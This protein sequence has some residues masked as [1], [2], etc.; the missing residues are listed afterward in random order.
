M[1]GNTIILQ[2]SEIDALRAGRGVDVLPDLRIQGPNPDA[3]VYI[4][5]SHRVWTHGPE[6]LAVFLLKRDASVYA[7][8]YGGYVLSAPLLAEP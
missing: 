5:M 7:T 6:P 8:K 4:V 2:Q 1:Q 3:P